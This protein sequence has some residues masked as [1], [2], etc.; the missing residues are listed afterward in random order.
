MT[1]EPCETIEPAPVWLPRRGPNAAEYAAT[2]LAS[3]VAA[4]FSAARAIANLVTDEGHARADLV[5]RLEAAARIVGTAIA[6]TAAMPFNQ[7]IGPHR[8]FDWIQ[9]SFE[10]IAL[11]RSRF[12]GTL[13]DVVLA[14]IA[15]AVRRFLRKARLTDPDGVD[16]RVMA[17]V[18]MR[19][20]RENGKLGNRVAGWFVSLP[21]AERDPVERLARVQ[22]ET[23]RLKG[24]H[25]ALGFE[26]LTQ[27]VEW[28]GSAP[29]AIGTR[30]LQRAQ[31]PFHMVVT[32]VPGPRG[33]LHLLGARMLEAH[34]MVPLLGQLALGVALF[35]YDGKLSWGITADWD[36]VPDLH[37]FVLAVQHSFDR[38]LECA[39]AA[40]ERAATDASA[41]PARPRRARKRVRA[42]RANASL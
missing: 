26:A 22:E 19:G 24:R 8:R 2:E 23:A 38:L 16:F 25:D 21:I 14:V 18:S 41:P 36:L 13:N 1:P 42:R 5:E 37:E 32:N 6:G 15:G 12:G 11:I 40:P 7:P 29:I 39:R 30:L 9:V 27:A 35:S 3:R 4:P 10:D 28:I 20:A 34:P 33:P 17:P 31:P